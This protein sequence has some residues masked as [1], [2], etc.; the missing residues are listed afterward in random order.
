MHLARAAPAL[1]VRPSSGAGASDSEESARNRRHCS[2][3]NSCARGRAHSNS[4]AALPR[5]VPSRLCGYFFQTTAVNAHP[6]NTQTT[7]CLR[8]HELARR[9]FIGRCSPTHLVPLPSAALLSG[10]APKEPQT[11][12]ELDPVCPL[13]QPGYPSRSSL[14]PGCVTCVELHLSDLKRA[15]LRRRAAICAWA[16]ATIIW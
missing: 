9:L 5:C 7:C 14:P 16:L 13:T 8:I 12:H 2:E 1:G 6:A 15:L 11:H 10:V 4:V 3:G